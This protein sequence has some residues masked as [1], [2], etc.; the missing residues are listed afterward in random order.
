MIKTLSFLLLGTLLF[1]FPVHV[2]A[3]AVPALVKKTLVKVK[4]GPG[5]KTV[6]ELP[7]GTRVEI[8]NDDRNTSPERKRAWLYVVSPSCSGW[9]RNIDAIRCDNSRETR[10]TEI[11]KKYRQNCLGD[12]PTKANEESP[13]TESIFRKIGAALAG[14]PEIK[15]NG[16]SM[17]AGIRGFS[18]EERLVAGSTDAAKNFRQLD[19]IEQVNASPEDLAAIEAIAKRA[20]QE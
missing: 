12:N 19:Y 7:A 9:M 4:P 8:L 16:G 3:N 20:R 17:A 6:C 13:V 1:S 18:D 11:M 15:Q 5:A 2:Q 14:P 10:S